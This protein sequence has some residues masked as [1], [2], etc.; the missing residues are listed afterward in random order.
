[1][2]TRAR[3]N[4]FDR[5]QLIVSIYRQFDGYP[6]G[7][8]KEIAEFAGG[9]A[10]INGI[11]GQKAGE[12]ANGMGCFAAQLI[13]YLK[14]DIGSVYIRDTGPDSQGE[15]YSYNLHS[16]DGKVW[17]DALAGSV[18]MFGN[19]GTAEA[20]MKSIFSGFAKDFKV[21]ESDD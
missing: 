8:G 9:M 20:E 19:P 1:M 16:R 10:I 15:E 11:S 18:T 2:G 5:N 7:L 13:R 21:D 12:A 6:D 17:I 3:V 4:I 14:G